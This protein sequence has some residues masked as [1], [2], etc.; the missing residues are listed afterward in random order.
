M[1]FTT[2]LVRLIPQVPEVRHSQG[3]SHHQYRP[4]SLSAHQFRLACHHQ[5][6]EAPQFHPVLVL[7]HQIVR[8]IVPRYLP[9]N[10]SP[11]V[12]HPVSVP[13]HLTPPVLPQA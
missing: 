2:T 8:Q 6:Q 1:D 5:L 12:S 3:A 13:Q 9:V 11:R 10:Q 7:Q 4:L